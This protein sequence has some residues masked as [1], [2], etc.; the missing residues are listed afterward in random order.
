MTIL[1][2]S[3]DIYPVKTDRAVIGRTAIVV[4]YQARL[5]MTH[6]KEQREYHL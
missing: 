2:K 1:K 5:N 4:F 3:A 6:T